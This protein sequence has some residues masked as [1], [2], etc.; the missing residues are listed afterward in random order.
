MFALLTD[1]G[2]LFLS[3]ALLLAVTVLAGACASGGTASRPAAGA[4]T[5]DAMTTVNLTPEPN[6]PVANQ[7]ATFRVRL[8]DASG[9]GVPGAQVQ[10]SAK[11]LGMAHGS[12]D[13]PATESGSGEYVTK[14]RPTMAGT[15]RVS[16]TAQ[17]GGATKKAD[18]DLQVK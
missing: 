18:F 9:Q 2:R 6:P 7:D 14:L 4:S 15:W 1:R 5:A 11:H 3:L 8:A 17:A 10:V 13:A 16:V 12:I